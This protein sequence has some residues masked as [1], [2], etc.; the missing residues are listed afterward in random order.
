VKIEYDPKTD[1]AYLHVDPSQ[2]AK[3]Q[4]TYAC[5]PDEVGGQIQLDF[6]KDGRLIGIDVLDASQIL[7][8]ALL[9]A[10]ATSG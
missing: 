10:E 5:D 1:A 8:K 4:R 6:D 3:A 2:S 7:P 9:R